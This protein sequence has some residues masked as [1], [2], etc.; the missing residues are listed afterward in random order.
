MESNGQF[1]RAWKDDPD[2]WLP[3]S[4]PVLI[5]VLEGNVKSITIALDYMIQ[6]PGV[7]SF[8]TCSALYRC[9]EYR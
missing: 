9:I 8:D 6:R 3:I 7:V 1:E 5:R 4:K 2:K